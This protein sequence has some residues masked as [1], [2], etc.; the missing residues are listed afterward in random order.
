[1]C[2]RLHG[3]FCLNGYR[4][5]SRRGCLELLRERGD[6]GACLLP[7]PVYM[8]GHTTCSVAAVNSFFLFPNGHATE[9]ADDEVFPDEGTTLR[10]FSCAMGLRPRFMFFVPCIVPTSTQSVLAKLSQAQ[11]HKRTVLYLPTSNMFARYLNKYVYKPWFSLFRTMVKKRVI[12]LNAW[13]PFSIAFQTLLAHH[14]RDLNL[15]DRL[16]LLWLLWFPLLDFHDYNYF[17]KIIS[18]AL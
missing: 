3:A 11:D 7:V 18:Y 4:W 6:R 15:V 10:K 17:S 14:G 8:Q 1:M 13:L 2:R 5:K 12:S 9:F 16:P